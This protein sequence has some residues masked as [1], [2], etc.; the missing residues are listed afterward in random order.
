MKHWMKPQDHS[1]ELSDELQQEKVEMDQLKN[2]FMK[3]L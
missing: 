2:M 3:D 1:E